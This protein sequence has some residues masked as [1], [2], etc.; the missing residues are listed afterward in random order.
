MRQRKAY[1]LGG[2]ATALVGVALARLV[3]PELAGTFGHVALG[4]G[5]LLVAAGLATLAAATRRRDA[6]AFRIGDGNTS[7]ERSP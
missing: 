7:G 4:A 3:A 1:W 6:E 2:T 5:Y